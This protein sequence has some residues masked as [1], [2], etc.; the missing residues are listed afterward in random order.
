MA[1]ARPGSPARASASASAILSSPSKNRRFC[2]R[3][4]S[5][6]RRMSSSPPPG[7]PSAAV[8]Q[9]S[10]NIANARKCV[11]SCS[12]ASRPSSTASC[13]TRTRSPRIRWNSAEWCRPNASVPLFVMAASRARALFG[14]RHRALDFAER[15]QGDRRAKQDGD[16]EV[17]SEA[18]GEIRRRGRAGTSRARVRDVARLRGN[19][20][21][22][23]GSPR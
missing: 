20:R 12:R 22:T 2:S 3:R 13:A 14:Q 11:R 16:A 4:R 23:G 1:T 7:A 10:K 15:P 17:N 21:R 6:P 8:A 9:P 19:L 5:T 18:K